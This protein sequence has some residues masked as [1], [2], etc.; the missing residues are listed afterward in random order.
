MSN[1]KITS[2]NSLEERIAFL[3][4]RKKL[5]MQQI[6][7]EIDAF[8]ESLKPSNLIRST[9]RSVRQS[10]EIKNDLLHGAIG[11]ATGFLANK[12]LLSKLHGPWKTIAS[13][14]IQ[15][16]FVNVAV[17]YPNDIKEKVISTLGRFLRS[18]KVNNDTQEGVRLT[19]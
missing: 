4:M 6:D 13:L 16:G 17:K 5:E 7:A 11:L 15:A 8:K 14:L 3:E 10:P 19:D 18:L 2:M 9:F 1:S 12:V